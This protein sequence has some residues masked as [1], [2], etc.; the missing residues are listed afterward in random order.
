MKKYLNQLGVFLWVKQNN[1]PQNA[2]EVP[3][4]LT[5]DLTKIFADD[6][7]FEEKFQA[8]SEE[9]SEVDKIRELWLKV[10]RNF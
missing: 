2:K 4:E 8:L 9:L 5:W 10:Q 6:A 1:L 3:I 7:A